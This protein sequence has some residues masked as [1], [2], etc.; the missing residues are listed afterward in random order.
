MKLIRT[1]AAAAALLGLTAG[2]A[3]AALTT[4]QTF[5]GN[6]GVS[7]DGWGSVT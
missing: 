4:F 3:Q 6:Y 1:L 7:T 2:S 5:S